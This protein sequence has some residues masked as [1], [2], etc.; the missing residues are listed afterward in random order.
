MKSQGA[1]EPKEQGKDSSQE[2]KIFKPSR[3]WKPSQADN[4]WRA[5][6]SLRP[7]KKKP[8]PREGQHN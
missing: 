7:Q 6:K 4:I 1:L 2:H 5:E 8:K 3:K